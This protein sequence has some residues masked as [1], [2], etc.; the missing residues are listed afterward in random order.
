MGVQFARQASCESTKATKQE[1]VDL[2][3]KTRCT[4][5]VN[6]KIEVMETLLARM[7]E[8]QSQMH[9]IVLACSMMDHGQ[10]SEGSKTEGASYQ[11]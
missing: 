3:L 9:A 4:R 6:K 2:I 8:N 5:E 10:A 1:L 7:V 11:H